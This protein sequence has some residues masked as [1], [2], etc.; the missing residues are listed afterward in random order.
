[1][2]LGMNALFARA[3]LALTLALA[4]PVHAAALLEK[5]NLFELG[6]GGYKLYRIPGIVVTSKGTILAYCE[7]RRTGS[8]WAAMDIFIRRSADGGKTWAAPLKISDVPGP[9][10]KNPVHTNANPA[11]VTYNNPVAIADRDGVVHFIFCLEYQRC[12]YLRS[13]DD[14]ITWNRPVEITGAFEKFRSEYDWKIIATGPGHG[15]QLRNG[16]LLLPVWLSLGEGASHHSPSVA[17]VI[18]SDDHGTNWQRGDIAI[19]NSATTPN[20]SEAELI[21]LADDRVEMNARTEAKEKQRVAAFSADGATG[22]SKPMLQAQLPA[23]VC[24]AG[25]VRY[26][27]QS[28]A[29]KN[30]IL[31]SQPLPAAGLHTVD[32]KQ[33]RRDLTIRLS[34]DEAETWPVQKILESGPAAYSDLAVQLDGTVLCFYERGK[35]EATGSAYGFLTLAHFNLAW[36]TGGNDPD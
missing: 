29:K 9:K 30:R 17:A 1:M 22:W 25:I 3:G 33:D 6:T 27:V 18:F 34:Y 19:Q 12:F 16:R 11:E 8:D 13:D 23:P 36:L 21:Q 26:S 10:T 35:G 14:G 32:S 7:A 24:M 5:T 20:P 31:F 4:A 28:V 2:S 15:I